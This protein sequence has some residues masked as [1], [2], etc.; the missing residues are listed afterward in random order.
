MYEELRNH[1]L[2][3]L[4]N[5]H[6]NPLGL[7][8]CIGEHKLSV[9]AIIVHDNNQRLVSKSKYVTKLY[10]VNNLNE[11]LTILL[12]DYG[13]ESLKPF[14]FTC[15]DTA[16]DF[17]NKNYK[18][19]INRFYFFNSGESDLVNRYMNKNH[20]VELAKSV[21]MNV[22]WTK[23]VQTGT[24]P[25]DVIYPLITK[26]I[27]SITIRE[28]KKLSY[29]CNNEKELK[30]AFGKIKSERVLLQQF[31]DKKNELG[32]DGYAIK[33]GTEVLITF[34]YNYK[35]VQDG[36]FSHYINI[37]TP[38]KKELNDLVSAYL[39]ELNY[40]GI[41]D[42]EF[43]EDKNG[44]FY[45]CEI[46]LR[47]SAWN[48]AATTAGMPM[49]LMWA[50]DMLKG[51]ISYSKLVQIPEGYSAMEGAGYLKNL[52]KEHRG[53]IRFLKEFEGVDCHF[54]YNTK[55]MTPFWS[56]IVGI[57]KRKVNKFIGKQ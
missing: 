57:I 13:D 14:I 39:K 11:G 55:D 24:I 3:L 50:S 12:R 36:A 40:E 8:R 44:V 19:L 38:K 15:D 28:W 27:D 47:N 41:F 31:V 45:F 1:K 21:G 51:D 53:S 34:G 33:N 6:Y 54:I 49:P 46:N 29:I 42:V 48:Y 56:F 32:I 18:L 16:T 26:A 17:L 23:E 52:I 22:L 5:E 4:G 9:I 43:I 37:F 10:F 25:P 2:I 7:V 30:E 20:Q 35:Y